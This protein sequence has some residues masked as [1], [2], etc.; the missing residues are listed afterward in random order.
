MSFAR[1]LRPIL[2]AALLAVVPAASAGTLSGVVTNGT[3]GKKVAH[4]DVTLIS[5]AGGM[6]ELTT[7]QTGADGRYSFNRP[8]IGLG[9]MLIRVTYQSVSYH[10]QSPPGRETVD[11]TVFD[12]GA[13]AAAVQISMR[14]IIFQPNGQR[15]LVGEEYVITNSAKPPATYSNAKGTFEFAVPDGAQIGQVSASSPGGMPTTQSTI[16]KSKNRYA[17]D[18]PLKP[19]DSNIRISYDL[20]Y[21]PARTTVRPANVLPAARMMLAAPQGVQIS[22][23]GFSPA[24]SDQGFTLM[25]RENVPP[26]AAFGITL[27]G[28]PSAPPP[29]QGQSAEAGP[30]SSGRDAAPAAENIQVLSPRISSF[31]YIVLGGMGLFFL[32]GFFFLMRQQRAVTATPNDAFAASVAS[33]SAGKKSR[34]RDNSAERPAY[35]TPSAAAPAPGA[36]HAPSAPHAE[37]SAHPAPSGPM[38]LEDMKETLF[39]LEFRRQA[40]TIAEQEY[41]QARSQV[42]AAIRA[43]VRG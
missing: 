27:S 38:N 41:A 32:A 21:D 23:D 33:A 7:T 3:N 43:F 28:S 10:Q 9:P 40:G 19:G 24:G 4:A 37:A 34:A 1:I 42:E 13:P 22:G 15:L 31:Q 17:I 16:D 18:F 6:Q 11:M 8:E 26:G 30:P 2:V 20:P 36:A 39:R 29:G 14:T 12:A 5:L 25:T 35:A